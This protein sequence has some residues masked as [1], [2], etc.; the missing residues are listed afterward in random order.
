[1][2][3]GWV[4]AFL[5]KAYLGLNLIKL[6]LFKLN[7]VAYGMGYAENNAECGNIAGNGA[8]ISPVPR[9]NR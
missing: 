6:K 2:L 8:G 9:P 3:W 7:S 5:C 1:M 4:I